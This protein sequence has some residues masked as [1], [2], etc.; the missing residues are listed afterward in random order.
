MCD[1]LRGLAWIGILLPADVFTYRK[2]VQCNICGWQGARFYPNVGSGYFNLDSNCPRCSCI[3]RYRS[4]AAILD[5]CTDFFTPDM[6]VIEAAPVRTFQAYCLWRKQGKNYLSFDRQVKL[7][8]KKGDLTAMYFENNSCDYFLCFHVSEHVQDDVA[9]VREIFRVLRPGGQAVL[10]VPIDYSLAD[11]LEY[12]R[13]NP[14][15]TGHVRR[16]S[17]TGFVRRL[18][19]EGF[20]V[21]TASVMELFSRISIQRF[22]F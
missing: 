15:E 3:P 2:R 13:P 10:Q 5:T 12:G 19:G 18:T 20:Q 6:A 4:L 16:Y 11:T 7:A 22:S 14:R 17:E 1:A 8:M 9:A 21:S